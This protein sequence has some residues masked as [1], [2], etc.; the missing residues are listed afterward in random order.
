M[1]VWRSQAPTCRSETREYRAKHSTILRSL[2]AAAKHT[3]TARVALRDAWMPGCKLRQVHELPSDCSC[4]ACGRAIGATEPRQR[5]ASNSCDDMHLCAACAASQACPTCGASS[6]RLY[7]DR[8]SPFVLRSRVFREAFDGHTGSADVVHPR[9]MVARAFAAYGGRPLLGEAASDGSSVRW[10]SYAHCATAARRLAYELRRSGAHGGGGAGVAVAICACNSAGWRL[11]QGQKSLGANSHPWGEPAP[12]GSGRPR[13][14]RLQMQPAPTGRSPSGRQ[15]APGRPAPA[16]ASVDRQTDRDAR[17]DTATRR[18]TPPA[19]ELRCSSP[20]LRGGSYQPPTPHGL[21]PPP[22]ADPPPPLVTTA[23]GPP[24]CC[25]TGPA[26]LPVYRAS[27][28]TPPR[29]RPRRWLRC[30]APP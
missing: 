9:V 18:H 16:S 5:C 7:R 1:Q 23:S 4:D 29:R 14:L 3:N 2:V 30:A 27:Q 15:T 8:A 24:G 17:P 25:A 26:R 6:D 22:L 10:W 13:L 11:Q 20:P 28:P 21:W 12:L 19:H